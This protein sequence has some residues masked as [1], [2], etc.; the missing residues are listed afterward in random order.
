MHVIEIRKKIEKEE[1]ACSTLL[2]PRRINKEGNNS[3]AIDYR[4]EKLGVNGK[5]DFA[6]KPTGVSMLICSLRNCTSSYQ[7]MKKIGLINFGIHSKRN[8]I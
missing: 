4:G 5:K 6:M 7:L 3:Y 2:R 8:F 1:F